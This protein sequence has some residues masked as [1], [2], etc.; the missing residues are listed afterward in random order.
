MNSLLTTFKE[1][2][3]IVHL[4]GGDGFPYVVRIFI[5]CEEDGLPIETENC[6][7]NIYVLV[8]PTELGYESNLFKIS[9]LFNSEI[10]ELK[11]TNDGVVLTLEHS[12]FPRTQLN[13][14]IKPELVKFLK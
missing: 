8:Q 10:S 7:D 5:L 6:T 4:G 9:R 12:R 2:K 14:L 13:V 11:N 3:Q 1:T